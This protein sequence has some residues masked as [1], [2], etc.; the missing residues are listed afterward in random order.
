MKFS[1]VH[2]GSKSLGLTL[3]DKQELVSE[4]NLNIFIYRESYILQYFLACVHLLCLNI[5]I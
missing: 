4:I 1:E 5:L 3:E 2:E